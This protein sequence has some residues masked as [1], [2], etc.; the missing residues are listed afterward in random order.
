MNVNDSV[1]FNYTGNIQSW[2]VPDT[3]VYELEVWGAQGGNYWGRFYSGGYVV[4]TRTGG[5]GGY[6]KGRIKLQKGTTYYIGVGGQGI[7]GT[8]NIDGRQVGGGGGGYNGG[9]TSHN[10]DNA[11]SGGNMYI[12][13]GGGGYSHIAKTSGT[14]NNVAQ[15]DRLIVAGGGGG[16]GNEWHPNGYD[17]YWNGSAGSGQYFDPSVEEITRTN[18]ARSGNGQC[19][20][21]LT[22]KSTVYLGDTEADALYLG[23]NESDALYVGDNEA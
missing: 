20:I 22:K 15:A 16:A 10:Y 4:E 3:G 14:I 23:D 9:Y 12:A 6:A 5:G 13:G 7:T 11:P 21:T 19:K 2:T 18:G 8:W 17:V 1:T